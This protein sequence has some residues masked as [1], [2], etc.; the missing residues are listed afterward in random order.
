[1]KRRVKNTGP[2]NLDRDLVM[3]RDELRCARC[4]KDV[5]FYIGEPYSLQHRRAKGAGGTSD[6]RRN[7]PSNLVLLCGSATSP[8]GCHL[9]CEQRNAE[10]E[11]DGFVVSLNSRVD[12]AA[13]PVRHAMHGL[14]YLTDEGGWLPAGEP[15]VRLHADLKAAAAAEAP[16]VAA[17]ETPNP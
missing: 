2:T 9:F 6:P 13:V 15:A 8:G 10:A 11:A 4:G 3:Q 16:A 12:P 1:M 17:D 7:L 5:G 14:I